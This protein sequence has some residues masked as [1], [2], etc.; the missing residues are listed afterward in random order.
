MEV[1]KYFL[2]QDSISPT[3]KLFIND[4]LEENEEKKWQILINKDNYLEKL[5]ELEIFF[6]RYI[7]DTIYKKNVWNDE[8][9]VRKSFNFTLIDKVDKQIME[10]FYK[11]IDNFFQWAYIWKNF[12]LSVIQKEYKDLHYPE[13][14]TKVYFWLYM[15][16]ISILV[17]AVSK[18]YDVKFI[19]EKITSVLYFQDFYSINTFRA[20]SCFS[21]NYFVVNILK[22]QNFKTKLF[23]LLLL[24]INFIDEKKL[25]S[26]FS[27]FTLEEKKYIKEIIYAKHKKK[28]NL[29]VLLDK[30][31]DTNLYYI[32]ADYYLTTYHNKNLYNLLH[33]DDLLKFINKWFLDEHKYSL[34][35]RLKIYWEIENID[36]FK[37]Y[38]VNTT[39]I[40][41][42]N[43]KMFMIQKKEKIEKI[44]ELYSNIANKKREKIN[45]FSIEIND[46]I[47]T[48]ILN[49]KFKLSISNVKWS[50]VEFM[51]NGINFMSDIELRNKIIEYYKEIKLFQRAYK[52]KIE[53]DELVE[54][55]DFL[56]QNKITNTVSCF[57]ENGMHF[58][59]LWFH[60]YNESIRCFIFKQ[61]KTWIYTWKAVLYINKDWEFHFKN[62]Y[63]NWNL[64]QYNSIFKIILQ[65]QPHYTKKTKFLFD[66]NYKKYKYYIDGIS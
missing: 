4:I 66:E 33:W 7:K 37:M 8:I 57:W 61:K 43:F 31:N 13:F 38:D 21:E 2:W 44:D 56:N 41:K 9:I 19:R 35:A 64:K 17:N 50:L 20:M 26:S 12:S 65:H 39:E 63:L 24:S 6:D 3:L 52:N 30:D 18:W 47:I 1:L 25:N 45:N 53:I 55:E 40:Y 51:W 23:C 11:S 27:F 58:D 5:M 62:I 15:K 60:Y 59:T 14:I 10:L 28:N 34:I 29:E 16:D 32:I 36:F 48:N 49:N 46:E 42:A 22:K 54:F